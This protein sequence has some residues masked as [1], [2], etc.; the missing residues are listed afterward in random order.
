[1]P[2]WQGKSR[3]KVTGGRRIFASK[4]RRYEIGREKQVTVIEDRERKKSA[5][6]RGGGRKTRILGTN[7]V[8]VTNVKTNK[9]VKTKILTVIENPAN[10]FYVRRNIITKGAIID[11]ELGK[12]RV[13][14][15]PG[16]DGMINAV[17][18]SE[19]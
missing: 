19:K 1:M 5:R 15:R 14:S 3:R 7:M 12:A 2:L 17:L 13:T 16:Q 9:T 4:K 11:T 8:N 10:P 18:I 6:S